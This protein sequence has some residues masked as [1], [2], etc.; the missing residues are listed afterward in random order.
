MQPGEVWVASFLCLLGLGLLG[1][2]Q[3]GV[4]FVRLVTF[5]GS[6]PVFRFELCD[7][8]CSRSM[9][10]NPVATISVRVGR[11]SAPRGRPLRHKYRVA[12]QG[13]RSVGNS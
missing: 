4:W 12:P 7:F 5:L 8:G 2:G 1:L 9:A 3:L 13:G 10:A 6:A 11:S